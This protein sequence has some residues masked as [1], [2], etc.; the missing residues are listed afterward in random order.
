MMIN[1]V[2]KYIGEI[3]S[4]YKNYKGIGEID[5]NNEKIGYWEYY[6]NNG[7]L[8]Q[9]GS[10]V[11]GLKDGYWEFYWFNGQLYSKGNLV[12]GMKDGYWEFYHGKGFLWFK[13]NY[14]NGKFYDDK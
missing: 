11:N 4:R 6:F 3:N 12:N 2:L 8:R 1:K 13:G 14:I 7:L 9:K 5:D 10:Y